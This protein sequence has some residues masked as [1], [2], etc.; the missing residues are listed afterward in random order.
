MTLLTALFAALI[1]TVVWYFKDGSN[2]MQTG[3]LSL[4]YWGAS[5][6]W[7][8]DAVFAVIGG[9]AFFDISADDAVLGMIIVMFGLIAWIVMLLIADPKKVFAK[10]LLTDENK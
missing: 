4:M 2:R 3:T 7:L 8:V 9:E 10:S 5:L 6:M 1:S